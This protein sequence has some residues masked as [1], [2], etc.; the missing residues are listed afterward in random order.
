MMVKDS[1]DQFAQWAA[2]F[3]SSYGENAAHL[4]GHQ[5][6]I[7]PG[8][9]YVGVT[10]AACQL[11]RAVDAGG[12]PAFVTKQLKQIAKDNGIDVTVDWT[13]NEIVEEIRKKASEAEPVRLP[14]S[15]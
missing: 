13:P 3:A 15:D 8:V 1:D 4:V 5:V 9:Q 6:P 7:A 14:P 12:V 11:L 2:L 10:P